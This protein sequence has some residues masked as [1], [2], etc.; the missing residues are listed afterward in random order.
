MTQVEIKSAVVAL[1]GEIAP[2]VDFDTIDPQRDLRE[3]LDIDSID[4]LNFI[5]SLGREFSIEV[6]E[7]DYPQLATLE[8]CVAYVSSA[9]E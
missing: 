3:E 9:L 1:L 5:I 4:F 6:P 2:E 8:H 7:V